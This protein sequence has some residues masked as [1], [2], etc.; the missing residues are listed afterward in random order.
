MTCAI[1]HEP[2]LVIERVARPMGT[3]PACHNDCLTN[4]GAPKAL[5]TDHYVYGAPLPWREETHA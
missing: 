5:L 2:I 4:L 3:G 1:C